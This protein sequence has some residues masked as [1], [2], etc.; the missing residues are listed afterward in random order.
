M[1]ESLG[2]AGF[3]AC[4]PAWLAARH[5]GV[6]SGAD[7]ENAPLQTT[8]MPSLEANSLSSGMASEQAAISAQYGTPTFET[9]VYF[10]RA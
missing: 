4:A 5:S 1:S 7:A 3:N 9:P 8:C 2:A 10:L 6:R